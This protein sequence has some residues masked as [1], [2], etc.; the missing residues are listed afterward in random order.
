MAHDLTPR[1]IEVTRLISL[2]CTMREIAKILD[3]S[4]STVDNHRQSIMNKLGTDKAAL[5]TRLALKH[6]ISTMKDKLTA[7]EKRL[8]GRRKD[9]WN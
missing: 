3:L 4:P 2:G 5:V 1:E 9:G 7:K 8:S 6:R